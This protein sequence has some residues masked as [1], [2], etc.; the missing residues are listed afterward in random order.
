VGETTSGAIGPGEGTRQSATAGAPRRGALPRRADVPSTRHGAL[1][2]DR[3]A[4]PAGLARAVREAHGSSASPTPAPP[5]R[6]ARAPQA[7]PSRAPSR[8]RAASSCSRAWRTRGAAACRRPRA[9]PRA[10]QPLR[11]SPRARR[12]I[13][14]AAEALLEGSRPVRCAAERPVLP[15]RRQQGRSLAPALGTRSPAARCA[16]AFGRLAPPSAIS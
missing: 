8:R 12:R 4:P 3:A 10:A 11:P 13:A 5:P 2:E 15:E 6:R 9:W 1:R 16:P 14:S 7:R